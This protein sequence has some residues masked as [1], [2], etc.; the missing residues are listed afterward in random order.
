V[1]D[2]DFCA[3]MRIGMPHIARPISPAAHRCE[4]DPTNNHVCDDCKA[5]DHALRQHA[6][7][8][9]HAE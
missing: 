7:S 8:E 3:Q 1:T 5:V 4:C 9:D 2:Q 6:P